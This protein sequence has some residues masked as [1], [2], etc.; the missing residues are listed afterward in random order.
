[1]TADTTGE[2][3][4]PRP[5]NGVSPYLMMLISTGIVLPK[6]VIHPRWRHILEMLSLQKD[7]KLVFPLTVGDIPA[8]HILLGVH[9]KPW[10]AMLRQDMA[11]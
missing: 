11:A 6:G 7:G 3:E 1:M 9:A 5:G 2:M 8:L 10:I 4:D